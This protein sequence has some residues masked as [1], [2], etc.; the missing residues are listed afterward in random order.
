MSPPGQSDA[1]VDVGAR[2]L[3]LGTAQFGQPY[4]VANTAG[5]VPAEAVAA[6]TTLARERGIDTLDTAVAYGDSEMVLGAAGVAAWRVVSKLPPLPADTADVAAWVQRQVSGSLQRLRIE[7]LD[8]LLL[9]NP[10]DAHGPRGQQLLRALAVLKASNR[11]GAAGISIYDPTELDALWPEWR[12]DI[13]QAPCNVLDRRLMH[14]GWL[15]RL[16]GAGC[17]VARALGIPAGPAA[18]ARRTATAVVR[19]LAFVAGPLA[20]VVRAQAVAPLQAALAFAR[21]LAG[22]RARCGRRGLLRA[23]ACSCSRQHGAA[24]S[25]RRTI[26]AARSASFSSRRAGG[27][28]EDCRHRAGAHGIDALSGQGACKPICGD[29]ADRAAAASACASDAQLDAIVLATSAIRATTRSPR[30]CAT[31]VSTC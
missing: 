10:A 30:T 15:A 28:H 17:A 31:S 7:R 29:A 3:A 21:T 20:G 9:H 25:R 18:H 2:C 5:Q 22:G 11:I 1:A 6:I 8:G 24:R 12:P 26:C 19:A 14:S 16:H 23:T 27:R 13:V 4:G